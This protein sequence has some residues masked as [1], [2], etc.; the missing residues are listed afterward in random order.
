MIQRNGNGDLDYKSIS[1]LYSLEDSFNDPEYS[2][3][4][5]L[6]KESNRVENT[7]INFY[8]EEKNKYNLWQKVE[9]SFNRI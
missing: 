1:A 4:M 5:N 8:F 3:I 6:F 7:V 9:P 2:E